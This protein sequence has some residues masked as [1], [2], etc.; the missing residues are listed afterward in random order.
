MMTS[1]SEYRLVLRQDNAME[2]LAP[3]GRELGLVG[4]A[5]WNRFLEFEE[6]KAQEM[7]RLHDTI[8]PP[9]DAVNR[10]LEERGTAP[11][12]TGVRLK[13]LMRRP[14]LGYDALAPADPGRPALSRA[15]M[16]HVE[17]EVK[18]E[19]YIRRQQAEIEEQR[20]LE[21][22]LLPEHI[23]YGA[24]TGLRLEAVEK[25]KK[26]QPR[27]IGQAGRISGVSPADISVLLIWLSKE[28]N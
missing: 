15:L 16:E 12:V 3:L 9:S 13:E 8:I 23:D 10:L 14:Q 25:L 22:R 17:T 21:D 2:R 26:I 20:R 1:R 7:Q 19:G 5:S 24:I 11:L 6:A 28:G 27:S 18:Y 4:D